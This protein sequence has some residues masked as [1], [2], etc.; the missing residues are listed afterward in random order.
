LDGN[1]GIFGACTSALWQSKSD[2]REDKTSFL[3]SLTPHFGIYR[4]TGADAHN[5]YLYNNSNT[6][7]LPLGF[8][9][10]GIVG[11]FRLYI[12]DDLDKG[13][14]REICTSFARGKLSQSVLFS[15]RAVEVWGCGGEKAELAQKQAKI[16]KEKEIERRRMV[17]KE[18]ITE[19]WDSGPSKYLMD[20]GGKTGV[21]DEFLEDVRKIR[22]MRKEQKKN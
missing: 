20:L 14:S 9:F 16:T 5:V 17:K 8:G 10:G 7:T 19:T 1:G 18:F 22:K 12:N 2:F 21:S 4:A 6:R 15:V 11:S 3:F 13:E